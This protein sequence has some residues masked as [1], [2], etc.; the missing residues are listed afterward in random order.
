MIDRRQLLT[1][2]GLLGALAPAE[3]AAASGM[4][5]ISDHQASDL[6]SALKNIS[7]AI[8]Q[9]AAQ[10][11]FDAI[12]P[13]RARQVDYL[14]AN[15]KFP[16]FIDVSRRV[17]GGVRL[18]RQAPAAADDRPRCGGPVHVAAGIHGAGASP[19]RRGELHLD[20][21]RQS[22]EIGSSGDRVIW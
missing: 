11:S 22:I 1:V 8:G 4:G 6:V 9:V 12:L 16:D 15:S 14:K 5:Q 21:L 2:G 17:D 7:G 3:E 10:Q 18:A 19:R 20:A 13:V